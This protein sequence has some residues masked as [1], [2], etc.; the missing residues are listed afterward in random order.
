M[1]NAL[2]SSVKQYG[3]VIHFNDS[4][5][6][7]K[8]T[9]DTRTIKENDIYIA[10]KGDHFDGYDFIQDMLKEKQDKIKKIALSSFGKINELTLNVMAK[11][12]IPNFVFCCYKNKKFSSYEEF[13]FKETKF[14]NFIL[15]GRRTRLIYILLNKNVE[16]KKLI[17]L[18]RLGRDFPYKIENCE[19]KIPNMKDP[20]S[21]VWVENW[22]SGKEI[23]PTN[24]D[25]LSKAIL[26]L[27]NFQKQSKTDELSKM[28]KQN[29]IIWFKKRISNFS[30]INNEKYLKYLN[31]YEA[32][33]LENKIPK[34]ARHGDFWYTNI[35]IDKKIDRI[36]VIDWENFSREGNPFY[37]FLTFMLHIMT[38]P[39]KNPI[40][41]FEESLKLKGVFGEVMNKMKSKIEE[42]FGFNFNLIILLRFFIIRNI[43]RS[44]IRGK[45]L[46]DHI[47]MLEFLSEEK[48]N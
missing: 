21:R 17:S 4:L 32:Y 1:I 35:L 28:E 25:H 36:N 30:E 34:V 6:V 39:P 38:L 48:L 3:K 23:D 24:A 20:S 15:M 44:N 41:V 37:D 8:I 11:R 33:L 10:I 2:L 5:R 14:S 19:R 7:T 13:L 16:P 29:E 31:D 22:I 9:Q 45:K 27:I 26:W 18:Q 46:Q 12:L 43:I 47:H 40:K 42:H